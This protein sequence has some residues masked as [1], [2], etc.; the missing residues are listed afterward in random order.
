MG[1]EA[2]KMALCGCFT[3]VLGWWCSQMAAN[4]HVICTD[5]LQFS[6]I[7]GSLE[8]R[9]KAAAFRIT[10]QLNTEQ[11]SLWWCLFWCRPTHSRSLR[12]ASWGDSTTSLGNLFHC[13]TLHTKN[14]F[15]FALTDFPFFQ[16]VSTASC[17]ITSHRVSIYLLY[18]PRRYLDKMKRSTSTT[19]LL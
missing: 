1:N 8:L 14:T 12:S 11:A 18:F 16:H 17:H 6:K 4:I 9:N 3:P 5:H 2:S 15:A 13:V 7:L 10:E 19:S